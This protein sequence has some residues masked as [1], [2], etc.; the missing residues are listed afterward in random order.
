MLLKSAKWLSAL[1]PPGPERSHLSQQGE[2]SSWEVSDSLTAK[3]SQINIVFRLQQVFFVFSDLSHGVACVEYD[4][5]SALTTNTEAKV[6]HK[7]TMRATLI[8]ILACFPEKRINAK[9]QI[10]FLVLKLGG[11]FC[12]SRLGSV[13]RLAPLLGWFMG[14]GVVRRWRLII[15][16]SPVRCKVTEEFPR[17]STD[18]IHAAC[19]DLDTAI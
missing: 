19:P 2:D 16:L 6:V 1:E 15:G 5:E 18:A 7:Q 8:E 12:E 10:E 3:G 11:V 13:S 9:L 17:L 4:T 14:I